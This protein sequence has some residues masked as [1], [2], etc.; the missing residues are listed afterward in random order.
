[1]EMRLHGSVFLVW[2][3]FSVL[4]EAGCYPSE[5]SLPTSVQ[6]QLGSV[7]LLGAGQGEPSSVDLFKKQ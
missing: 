5:G 2:C 6:L 3:L 1:M 4:M 7:P